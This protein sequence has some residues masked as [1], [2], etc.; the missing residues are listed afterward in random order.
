MT[1][2]V[3]K[4]SNGAN[5]YLADLH[6]HTPR[7][8]RFK[9]ISGV[10][11]FTNDG[12]KIVA[13]E[14]IKSAKNNGIRIL[15]ITEH[16]DVSFIDAIRE[17]AKGK[18]VTIFPGFEISADSGAGG[19]HIICLFEP[20]TK[21]DFLDDLIT[22]LGLPRSERYHPD[23]SPKLAKKQLSEAVDFVSEHGGICI[24][25]HVLRENGIL[26]KESM[27]GEPRVNA[28]K[29][30]KLLAAEIPVMRSELKGFAQKTFENSQDLYKRKRPIAS[31][32][33]SDARSFDDIGSRATW[34]KVSCLTLEGLKQAFLDWESRVRHSD[35]LA[36]HKFSKVISAEWEGGFLDGVKINFNENLN[37]VIGGK[38]TGKSTVLETL[39]FAFGNEFSPVAEKANEQHHEILKEVFKKGSKI[40]VTVE[41][42]YPTP[43]RYI[44]ER[45][46]N[47]PPV[48]KDKS[49][50][51]LHDLKPS[52]IISIESYGQKEIYEISKNPRFQLS[53]IDRFLDDKLDKLLAEENGYIL[54]IN[55]YK[56][57]YLKLKNEIEGLEEQIS[58]LPKLEEQLERYKKS[59]LPQR[60]EEKRKYEK[61]QL[62]MTLVKKSISNAKISVEKAKENVV[63]DA[64]ILSDKEIDELPNKD[65]F[66]KL[67]TAF[68]NVQKEIDAGLIK[69][70]RA[71]T[72]AD[73]SV[74]GDKG[75]ASEWQKKY[76][77]QEE[78]YQDIVRGLK[79]DFP[80]ID[81]DDF[82]DKENEIN[83][84]KPLTKEKKDKEKECDAA[85]RKRKELIEKLYDNRRKQFS[86]RDK[87]CQNIN[88]QLEGI[89][90]ISVEY[91]GERSKFLEYLKGLRSGA[92]QLEKVIENNSFSVPAFVDAVKQGADKLSEGF[93]V[94]AASAVKICSA[95]TE[96]K[97]LE[98]EVFKVDTKTTISLNVG[99][100]EKPKYQNTKR[101]SVGQKCT[102]ILTLIL[103]ESA[104]PIIVDQPEDDLDNTFIFSDIVK[105]LRR[106]KERRQ[107]IVAT[108]NANIPVLGD[109]E[110]ICIMSADAEH[111]YIKKGHAGSIDDK[112]VRKPVET[113]LEGGREAFQMRKEKYG[114]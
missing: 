62:I 56:V 114:F 99:S 79:K 101:L 34:I 77:E 27:S 90:N 53:L 40:T 24:A 66:V 112:S 43:K 72:S 74:S 108:H 13:E 104:N 33:F 42:H 15:G 67:K 71:I 55:Q 78:R 95:L 36:H 3:L 96:E 7:D 89:L 2:D 25:A 38:G 106:E 84:L 111:G 11:P 28:W 107:F 94:S 10:D 6:V 8:K 60:L 68:D 63:L 81:A 29:N 32:N 64:S 17:A 105:R 83:R 88:K 113:I 14:Y 109:A 51:L 22:Q 26:K 80:D 73:N 23:G 21:T 9:G 82:I 1:K 57:D 110:L 50:S 47:Q 31:V 49:G 58:Q 98:L 87:T 103:L 18:D 12:K 70:E 69:I 19:I 65:L 20:D 4:M 44:I 46:Y 5:F 30:K 35:E 41:A 92:Q 91:E 37:C 75:F 93:G 16:N 61:E 45:I 102:S 54:Q 76:D 48:V 100:K 97:L 59:G 52:D 39:R 85:R 86:I